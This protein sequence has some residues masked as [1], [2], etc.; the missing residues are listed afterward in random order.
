LT[1]KDGK[2]NHKHI[3]VPEAVKKETY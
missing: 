3:P 2:N 1:R